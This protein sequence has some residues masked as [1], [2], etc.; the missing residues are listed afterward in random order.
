MTYDLIV[1]GAGPAGLAAAVAASAAGQRVL[2]CERMPQ[3]GRKLLV[4]GGGRCN[5]TTSDSIDAVMA[6][7]GR[8]G[9][10][11]QPALAAFGPTAI[12]AWLTRANVP[13]V[14]QDDGCVFPVSQRARDVLD[15]FTF[16]AARGHVQIR[17]GCEVTALVVRDGAVAGVATSAGPLAA[18]RV[19]LAAG[20]RSYPELGSNGSGFELARQ[21]GLTLV[22]PVPA[23]VPLI[24]AEEWPRQLPGLVLEHGRVRIDA[25]GRVREGLTGPVLFTHR[26]LSGP[27]VLN[28]SGEVAARLAAGPVTVRVGMRADRDT[29]AWRGVI[30]GWRVAHGGRALHNLMAGELPR[31]LGEKLCELA[32]LQATAVAR[33]PRA[34]L[35]KLAALCGEAPLTITATQGWDHAMVT[36]G[37]VAL[38]ELDPRTLACRRLPGL[39]CVGEVVDLDGPCGGY[40]LTWAFASGWLAG[41]CRVK[42]TGGAST[43]AGSAGP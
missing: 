36:R 11:M 41:A 39:Q 15:A 28:L 7:F 33:A 22:P 38:D 42:P 5:V 21:A 16:A 8:H 27:P 26:G 30:D 4:T 3:P 29:A 24:T 1:V 23:L 37:G 17:C 13:S 32:E 6:A 40:N 34:K 43:S 18:G 14:V 10:F 9:R 35:E 20:G 2:V 12:R 31:S 19:I 25:K